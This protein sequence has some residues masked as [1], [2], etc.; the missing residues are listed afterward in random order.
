MK[1]R[2]QKIRR[3]FA[4]IDFIIALIFAIWGLFLITAPLHAISTDSHN[5]L[6]AIAPGLLLILFAIIIYKTGRLVLK[7]HKWGLLAQFLVVIF[8]SFLA[9]AIYLP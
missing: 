3:I 9:F 2:T 1:N 5:G 6:M 4:Y 7:Q 8:T